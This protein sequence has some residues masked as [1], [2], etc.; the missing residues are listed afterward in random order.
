LERPS[1][2]SDKDT[3]RSKDLLRASLL[4]RHNEKKIE[5]SDGKHLLQCIRSA[6][7]RRD[8]PSTIEP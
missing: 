5:G 6:S 4:S 8:S 3:A 7:I 1:K 2:T